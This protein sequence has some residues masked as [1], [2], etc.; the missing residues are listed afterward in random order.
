ML[1]GFGFDPT[2]AAVGQQLFQAGSS[3]VNE[4]IGRGW[5]MLDSLRYYFSVNNSYV[6]NK[7]KLLFFPFLHRN[8]QRLMV[9]QGDGDAYRAPRDDIN[10]PDLYIPAMGFLTWMM[11][12]A[13][14]LGQEGKFSPEAF[15][16]FA[17]K[18][19]A[20]VVLEVLLLKAGYYLLSD[21]PSPNTLVLAAWSSYKFPGICVNLL[22]YLALGLSGYY[23]ALAY[24]ALCMAFFLRDVMRVSWLSSASPAAG[25]Y[26]RLV[27]MLTQFVYPFLLG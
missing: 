14:L 12:W 3:M 17:S 25:K 19:F 5:A 7:L 13:L 10:A 22:A 4:R 1:P 27:V 18:G 26:F 8:W 20:V 21:A 15:G 11:L 6:K 9:S 23:L 16:A 24:N 2:T